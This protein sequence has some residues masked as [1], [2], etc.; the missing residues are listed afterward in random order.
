VGA[1]LVRAGSGAAGSHPWNSEYHWHGLDWLVGNAY[2]LAGLV[3]FAAV[4]VLA[5]RRAPARATARRKAPPAGVQYL[6][7]RAARAEAAGPQPPGER[8]M[9]ITAAAGPS[10]W[11]SSRRGR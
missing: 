7:A 10:P 6:I 5:R 4:A 9:W 8:R 2:I 11:S 1:D 3:A